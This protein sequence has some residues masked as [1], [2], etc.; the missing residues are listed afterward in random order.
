MINRTEISV[1]FVDLYMCLYRMR[2]NLP[3]LSLASAMEEFWR[4]FSEDEAAMLLDLFGPDQRADRLAFS[5]MS[6]M[7]GFEHRSTLDSANENVSPNLYPDALPVGN[8]LSSA[9]EEPRSPDNVLERRRTE[10]IA[11][12]EIR[13][14]AASQAGFADRHVPGV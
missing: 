6:G 2:I 1:F 4:L 9:E 5:G 11:A 8:M 7:S 10:A 3:F 13:P 12:H 14:A